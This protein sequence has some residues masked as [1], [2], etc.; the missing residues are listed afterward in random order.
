METFAEGLATRVGFELTQT[1]M[2]EHLADFI[3]VPDA[4][5]RRALRIV[6]ETTH[7]LAEPAGAASLAAAFRLRERLSGKKVALSMS[8]GNITLVQL[9]SILNEE[10]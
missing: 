4:E 9:K 2:R 5:L 8:G 6:L 10:S 7:N 1:I 3:L